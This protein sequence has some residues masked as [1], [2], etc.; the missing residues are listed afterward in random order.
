VLPLLF[1][2]TGF[3]MWNCCTQVI[4]PPQPPD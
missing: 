1:I 3:T 4:L 2:E